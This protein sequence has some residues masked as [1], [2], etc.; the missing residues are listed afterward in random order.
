MP[1]T[2]S[3]ATRCPGGNRDTVRLVWLIHGKVLARAGKGVTQVA[4]I[5]LVDD[6]P[7]VVDAMRMVLEWGDYEVATAGDATE[8]ERQVAV[9]KPDLILLD[10]MMPDDTEGFQFIW[11]LREEMADEVRGTPIVVI[12]AIHSKVDLRFYPDQ[13]GGAQSSWEHLPVQGFID[14]PATAQELLD[15]VREVLRE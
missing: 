12:S 3:P 7:D 8:A 9:V 13:S 14:K 15:K 1:Q 10:I 11:R 2:A 4:K 5:L 6:D